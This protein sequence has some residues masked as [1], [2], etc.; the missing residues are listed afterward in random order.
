[1]GMTE[2]QEK[3]NQYCKAIAKNRLPRWEE[4]PDI[5]L[6]M[7]QTVGIISKYISPYFGDDS[8]NITPSMINNYVK[9]KI[10]PSPVK[11]KYSKEHI[12]C[13]IMIS[14]LKQVLSMNTLSR[15]IDSRNSRLGNAEAYNS[16]CDGLEKAVKSICIGGN[17]PDGE[18]SD[19]SLKFAQVAFAGKMLSEKLMQLNM[20]DGE[21]SD[22]DKEKKKDKDKKKSKEDKN[23]SE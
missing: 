10:A 19:I 6:Y 23:Q 21:S 12:A 9:L 8:K 18:N 16:F 3:F 20:P 11:K 14:I 22:K 7:D 15:I 2:I 5:E 17:L 13:L 1:M 4:L